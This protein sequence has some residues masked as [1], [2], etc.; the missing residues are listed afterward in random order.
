MNIR[1]LLALIIAVSSV[2]TLASCSL[3]RKIDKNAQSADTQPSDSESY[4]TDFQNA[5]ESETEDAG[6]LADEGS[7]YD[8]L[9]G[10]FTDEDKELITVTKTGDI[11]AQSNGSEYFIFDAEKAAK[12]ADSDSEDEENTENH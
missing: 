5:P 7:A 8:F 9:M 1:K 2:M 6:I 12:P 3:I 4:N 11:I 10:S